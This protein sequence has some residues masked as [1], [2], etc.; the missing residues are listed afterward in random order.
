MLFRIEY[1]HQ[2]I[3]TTEIS[4]KSLKKKKK[5]KRSD[6]EL[7]TITSFRV[8]R[9]SHTVTEFGDLLDPLVCT[10]KNPLYEEK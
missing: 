8:G 10:K 3:A 1:L 6:T 5:I 9:F 2:K 4:G 7:V